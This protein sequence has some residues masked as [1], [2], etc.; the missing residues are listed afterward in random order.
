MAEG[1]RPHFS[2][3]VTEVLQGGVACSALVHSHLPV[4]FGFYPVGM[5][6]GQGWVVGEFHHRGPAL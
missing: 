1:P 5:G 6:S 2:D 4:G 3:E